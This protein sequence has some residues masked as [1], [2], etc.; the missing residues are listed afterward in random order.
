MA[1]FTV[2]APSLVPLGLDS[3]CTPR[4]H[5][6]GRGVIRHVTL[7]VVEAVSMWSA[8]LARRLAWACLPGR[9]G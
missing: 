2:P 3:G 8:N 9:G 7:A 1:T 6:T 4:R 5:G